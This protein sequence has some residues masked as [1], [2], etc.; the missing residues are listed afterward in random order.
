MNSVPPI[1]SLISGNAFQ[2]GS[3]NVAATSISNG[4]VLSVDRSPD[5]VAQEFEGVFTAML[6]KSM[7]TSMSE[8]GLFGSDSSDTYGGIFDM[9]MSRHISQ[10]SPLGIG[11][12]V[13]TYMENKAQAE[14]ELVG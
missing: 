11:E 14:T 4:G 9:F 3:G 5:A 12:M 13:K 2:A 8:E 6:L 10:G 1:N 7:R